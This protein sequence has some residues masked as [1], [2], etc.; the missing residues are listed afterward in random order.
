MATDVSINTVTPAGATTA[1]TLATLMAREIWVEDFGAKGDG[2][3]NDAPA[4]QAA[5]N[6][7]NTATGG[8]IRFRAKVYVV[9][10]AITVSSVPITFRGMGVSYG[11]NP[12]LGTTL[13]TTNA[14]IVPFTFTG[15]SHGSAIRDL[16]VSQAHPAPASAAYNASTDSYSLTPWM[17]TPYPYFFQFIGLYSGFHI[18]NVQFYGINK[19]IYATGCGHFR[20]EWIFGQWYNNAIW[21]ENCLD[22]PFIDQLKQWSYMDANVN[23]LV[24]Q[25]ANLDV[26]LL[27]RC[28]GLM[29]GRLDVLAA[30]S[31]IHCYQE[32]PNANSSI[33]SPGGIAQFYADTI[34]AEAVLYGAWMDALNN[35]GT[36]FYYFIKHFDHSCIDVTHQSALPLSG[37]AALYLN[38]GL[39]MMISVTRLNTGYNQASAI[40]LPGSGISLT[41]DQFSMNTPNFYFASNPAPMIS[42]NAST[43]LPNIVYVGMARVFNARGAALFGG[44]GYNPGGTTTCVCGPYTVDGQGWTRSMS[45]FP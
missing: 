33:G 1:S 2:T 30:R 14:S 41:I 36:I 44:S 3:T 37:A 34:S 29:L 26:L 18:D 28:D 6:S 4:I 24:Y 8:T 21:I 9:N 11:A 17:P 45:P 20:I 31:A 15:G 12:T 40:Y 13:L 43:P 22:T 16:A 7:L 5:I 39:P 25:Q 23:R 27:G 19:G 35:G 42:V 32:P 10:S 38:G